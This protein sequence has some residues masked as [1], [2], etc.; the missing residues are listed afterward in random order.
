MLTIKELSRAASYRTKKQEDFA[1][2]LGR[3][4]RDRLKALTGDSKSAHYY[5]KNFAIDDL[6]SARD[7]L[8]AG[9]VVEFVSE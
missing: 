1:G 9:R 6:I 4:I 3:E 5:A 8:R 2:E 7:E